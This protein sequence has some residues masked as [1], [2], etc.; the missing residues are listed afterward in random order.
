ME[1]NNTHATSVGREDAIPPRNSITSPRRSL[2]FSTAGRRR[3]SGA[4]F[5]PPRRRSSNAVSF[6]EGDRSI[7]MGPPRTS[8]AINDSEGRPHPSA[9]DGPPSLEYN[10]DGR[11]RRFALVYFWTFVVIDSVFMPIGLY[12]GL[13]YGTNLSPNTVFSIVTA[14]LGGISIF[15][16]FIRF[17]RL[18]KKGSTCRVIGGR[19]A[20]VR[21]NA[22]S[23]IRTT[24]L[25]TVN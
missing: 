1:V 9:G 4:P 8:I 14:A 17:W 15:E 21:Y 22:R 3:S 20:Y 6:G 23:R 5:S 16:Y 12:F 10:L 11:K 19:R 2:Q 24:E 18:F 25:L 13:W 7:P